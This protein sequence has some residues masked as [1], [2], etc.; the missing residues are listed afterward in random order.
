[1]ASS[2]GYINAILL[3]LIAVLFLDPLVEATG[4][5]ELEAVS[6]AGELDTVLGVLP[7]LLG[8]FAFVVVAMKV[9]EGV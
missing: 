8:L 6:Y 2:T 9:A 4:G 5:L 7:L 3:A 1:M